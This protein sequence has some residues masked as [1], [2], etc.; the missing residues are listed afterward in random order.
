M[1]TPPAIETENLGRI[2]RIRGSKKEAAKE[3]VALRDV[4]LTV[5]PG[6]LFGLLG[7]NGAGKTTLIK[8]ATMYTH[9]NLFKT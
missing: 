8:Y 9:N 4:N 1:T 2:Y 5:Q 6:E 7:P 3:L